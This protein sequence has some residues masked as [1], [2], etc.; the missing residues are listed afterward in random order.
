MT[1]RLKNKV[2]IVTGGVSGIGK[3]IAKDFLSEGAKVVITGRRE[4]LGNS[5]AK[6][7]GT[8]DDVIYL[9]Q[10]VSQ[11]DEWNTVVDATISKFGKFDILV[12]NAGVGASGKLLSQTSLAEWQNVMDINLTGNFLGIRAALNKMTAG[13]IVNVSSV[14]GMMA[15][16]P[17]VSPYAASK[18]GTRML[19]KAAAI[20]AI[21]MNKTIR[22]NSV[23]P[24]FVE[25][26]LLPPDM[27]LAMEQQHE[28]IPPFGQGEDVAK[29]VTYLASDEA[30]YTTGSELVL[31]GGA[32]AG[33][34]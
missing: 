31:D 21:A 2:A 34:R 13:S 9:K 6:E 19:T 12:N 8:S 14:L 11:E 29:A 17:G 22:V 23:H 1:D 10:D 15:G 20:E 4:E 32:L 33:R 28:S 16:M 18:G 26:A 5:V 30:K 3:A 7:L 27:K 24:G 25:T